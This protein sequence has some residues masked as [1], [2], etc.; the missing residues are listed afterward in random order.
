MFFGALARGQFV[1]FL[2]N[3]VGG[4]HLRGTGTVLG[5]VLLRERE[6]LLAMAGPVQVQLGDGY[7]CLAD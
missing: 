2:A 1:G 6:F 4:N 7:I 5:E 3:E